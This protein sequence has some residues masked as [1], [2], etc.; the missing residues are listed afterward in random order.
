MIKKLLVLNLSNLVSYS[1]A[2]FIASATN[3][4]LYDLNHSAFNILSILLHSIE[5]MLF[6][7]I[8]TAVFWVPIFIV[9]LILDYLFFFA[10]K[11]NATLAILMEW[12]IVCTPLI[13]L[14]IDDFNTESV[15]RWILYPIM[16]VCL[17]IGQ[18]VKLKYLVL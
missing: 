12:L 17:L 15:Q 6:G 18:I 14:L 1:I 13:Y 10:S 8:Y 3:D 7:M 16:I 9:L 5:N 11:L 2:I 4:Y